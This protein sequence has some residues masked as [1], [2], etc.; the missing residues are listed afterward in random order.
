[1][2]VFTPMEEVQGTSVVRWGEVE[3]EVKDFFR[4]ERAEEPSITMLME[5]LEVAVVLME[6][7]EVAEE[8]EATLEEV[9]EIILWTLVE[10]EEDL[11]I[12]GKISRMNAVTIQMDMVRSP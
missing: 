8:A 5:G 7:V 9:A 10:E 1:M 6:L 2:V 4:E 3:K 12:R 11:L